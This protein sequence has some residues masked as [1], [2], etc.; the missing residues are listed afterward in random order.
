M[1]S[2]PYN[3]STAEATGAVDT[4]EATLQ[5]TRRQAA[6]RALLL[7]DEALRSCCEEE[8][9]LATGPGGQ[10]RNK[11]ESG[12]RLVHPETGIR[13]A[14]TER[15][16]QAQNRAVALLR[17][18]EA[19]QQLS[20]VPKKR[21]ATKATRGSQRRRL[22]GKKHQGEKKKARRWRAKDGD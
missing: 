20:Q 5:R 17:L 19:L 12:V 8:F 1:D 6:R 11:T 18:R 7:D 10:H 2:N 13:V 4:D 22:A 21:V 3:V 15:R 16:S 14:A 9:F